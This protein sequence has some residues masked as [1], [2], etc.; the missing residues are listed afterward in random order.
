MENDEGKDFFR[1]GIASPLADV[2]SC[3][4][5]WLK[6]CIVLTDCMACL[7]VLAGRARSRVFHWLAL[8]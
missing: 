6:I 2:H 7:E 1:M 8:L 4:A 5:A 3:S